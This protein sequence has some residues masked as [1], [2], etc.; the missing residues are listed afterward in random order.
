M[1]LKLRAQNPQFWW[2]LVIGI[3]G[4]A[5]AQAG[6][7]LADITSWSMFLE[8]FGKVIANPFYVF[9]V[10]IYVAAALFD[11]T[12]PGYSDSVVNL[13]K[14]SVYQSAASVLLGKSETKTTTTEPTEKETKTTTTEPTE[15]ETKTTTTE[16]TEK[17]VETASQ[18]EIE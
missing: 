9:Q 2:T 1:N 16:P 10:V 8:V 3:I 7:E 5:I 13:S 6:Y 18:D 17:E 15:K 14:S 4:L 12:T 11:F